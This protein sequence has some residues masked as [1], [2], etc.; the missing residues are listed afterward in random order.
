[1]LDQRVQLHLQPI[2]CS[3]G[4]VDFKLE[5]V[6]LLRRNSDGSTSEPRQSIAAERLASSPQPQPTTTTIICTLNC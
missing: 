2:K 5:N 3:H 6:S 1:M 4:L